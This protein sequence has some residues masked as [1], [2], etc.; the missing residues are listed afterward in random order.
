LAFL[1][2]SSFHPCRP[3]QTSPI[4]RFMAK[5]PPSKLNYHM[6]ASSDVRGQ[7]VDACIEESTA[8]LGGAKAVQK[9]DSYGQRQSHGAWTFVCLCITEGLSFCQRERWGGVYENTHLLC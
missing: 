1:I 7:V 2:L 4:A 6:A 8:N 9:Q 5:I 3:P